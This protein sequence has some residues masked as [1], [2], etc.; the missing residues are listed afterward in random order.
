MHKENEHMQKKSESKKSSM[1]KR[2]I[3]TV[4]AI[5]IVFLVFANI[6]PKFASYEDVF[7]IMGELST[8]KLSFLLFL[9]VA[10]LACAWSMY[11]AALPA[12]SNKQAAQMMLSQNLISST[13]PLGGA[14]S[15]GVG[16]SI[17]HSYGFGATELSMILSVTGIWNTFIKF[18]LPVAAT[19][20]L[21]IEGY[22]S[23]DVITLAIVGVVALALVIVVFLLVFWK[24]SF[25]K[26]LGDAAGRLVSRILKPFH[27]GPITTWGDALLEFRDQ[28]VVAAKE[29]W[30]SLTIIAILYQLTT[31]W[32]FLFALRFSGVPAKGES[33]IPWVTAFAVF[34]FVRLISA[35]PLTPGAV[36][37]AEASYTGLLVAAGGPE[38][39]I[40]AGVLLFRGLTWLMPIPLGLPVYSSWLIR[41]RK[42]KKSTGLTSNDNEP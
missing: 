12:M 21:A 42:K 11:Q 10:N 13:L 2:L 30:L 5:G 27:K 31:F 20:L 22:H 29:Q 1:L 23:G 24:R 33:A 37:I 17:I 7:K 32:V 3:M 35:V 38:A 16:Y 8:T 26:K 14:W 18:A 25:A 39:Q 34:A 6:L 19:V 28:T 40:V 9:A 4:I 41:E 36:G 15:L